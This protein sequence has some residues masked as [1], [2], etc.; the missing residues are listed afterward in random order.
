MAD[1]APTA[2]PAPPEAGSEAT[3]PPQA[4]HPPPLSSAASTPA[5]ASLQAFLSAALRRAAAA[6]A[7]F[8]GSIDPP[9]SATVRVALEQGSGGGW[10]LTGERDEK[11][12]RDEESDR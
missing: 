3:Q 5:L 2:A 9:G 6:V 10:R 1:L 11:T 4:H 7:P 8:G 12:R